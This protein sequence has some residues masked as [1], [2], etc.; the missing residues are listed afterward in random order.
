MCS[1]ASRV[2]IQVHECAKFVC[3]DHL[4]SQVIGNQSRHEPRFGVMCTGK[5]GPGLGVMRCRYDD[6][7]IGSTCNRDSL[8]Q[9]LQQGAA[10]DQIAAYADGLGPLLSPT[11]LRTSVRGSRASRDLLSAHEVVVYDEQQFSMIRVAI[12]KSNQGSP[13]VSPSSIVVATQCIALFFHSVKKPYRP[14]VSKEK[15]KCLVGEDEIDRPNSY[16]SKSSSDASLERRPCL[17]R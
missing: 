5:Q 10:L 8:R 7:G 14:E 6:T 3:D 11:L 15:K 4:R 1:N 2:L 12:P 16:S 9:L 13:S 17:A